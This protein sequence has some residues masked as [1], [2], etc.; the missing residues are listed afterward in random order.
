[1]GF[2]NFNLSGRWVSGYWLVVL[3]WVSDQRFWVLLYLRF[4][5]Y[6]FCVLFAYLA[7]CCFEFA[8]LGF[9]VTQLLGFGCLREGVFWL[10]SRSFCSEYDLRVSGFWCSGWASIFGCELL[11]ELV[12][13][14]D[15]DLMILSCYWFGLLLVLLLSYVVA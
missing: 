4:G 1:M 6:T 13:G 11:S 10:C 3:L 2:W 14:A 7:G 15:L 8:C 9:G 5:C 12:F